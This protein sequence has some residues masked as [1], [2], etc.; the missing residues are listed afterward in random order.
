MRHTFLQLS[1]LLLLPCL[2]AGYLAYHRKFQSS[3]EVVAEGEP[4][5]LSTEH[6][7]VGPKIFV[8]VRPLDEFLRGHAPD[9]IQLN[10]ENW[11]TLISKFYDRWDPEAAVIVY[12]RPRSDEPAAVAA[13]LR[14]ESR[15]KNVFV[16]KGVW[17]EWPTF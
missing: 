6:W 14:S 5:A 13:R 7:P 9:A 3:P 15:L 1:L 12:G 2:P 16:F 4:G 10:Q 17:E 11:G 8:D